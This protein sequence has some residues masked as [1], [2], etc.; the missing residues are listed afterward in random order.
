MELVILIGGFLGAWLLVAGSVY[1]AA[2]ELRDQDFAFDHIREAGQQARQ[3]GQQHPSAWWWLLPPAKI[4]LEQKHDRAFRK[5]FFGKLNRTDSE[6]MLSLMNKS[7]A[8][9]Y[10]GLGGFLLAAKETYELDQYL[11]VNL[12]IFFVVTF[13]LLAASVFNTASHIRRSETILNEKK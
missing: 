1:Q 8:W 3:T 6:A 7:T 11:H 12:S 4:I 13:I 9:L 5:E 2:L 10:V